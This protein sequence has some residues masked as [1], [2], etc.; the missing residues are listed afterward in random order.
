MIE[1][2]WTK[3]E[4]YERSK[5][6]TN[7]NNN[8]DESQNDNMKNIE[9][10]AYTSSLNHDENTWE[11]LNQ[12]L[13]GMDFRNVN[14]REDTDKRLSER[15][16]VSQVSMNPYLTNNNYLDDVEARDT[17][18]KPQSTNLDREKNNSSHE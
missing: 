9:D 10:M 8:I 13:N 11:L 3:G 17:Y 7:Y 18:L 6:I 1:W 14:K 15:Q 16:M 12:S 2:K 5:R 4:M